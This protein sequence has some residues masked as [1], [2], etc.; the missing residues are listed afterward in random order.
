MTLYEAAFLSRLLNDITR[1][2]YT[3]KPYLFFRG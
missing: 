1:K 3:R 2:P